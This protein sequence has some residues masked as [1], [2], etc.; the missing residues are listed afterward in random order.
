MRRAPLPL[1]AP[2]EV[3]GELVQVAQ[4]DTGGTPVREVD[5]AYD[6]LNRLVSE[7]VVGGTATGF[8]YDSVGNRLAKEACSGDP[9]GGVG[10]RHPQYA[11]S[12]AEAVPATTVSDPSTFHFF[13]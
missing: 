6:A 1:R 11:L 7:T 10:V 4:A 5:Y 12:C 13:L 9:L 3:M 2:G 8:T